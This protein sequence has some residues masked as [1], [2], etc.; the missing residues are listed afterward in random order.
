MCG[1]SWILS[2]YG[3]SKYTA[4]EGQSIIAWQFV[5]VNCCPVVQI[6]GNSLITLFDSQVQWQNTKA[7]HRIRAGQLCETAD[8]SK[9][10]P[11]VFL[12][13]L[14]F[15]QFSCSNTMRFSLSLTIFVF[16]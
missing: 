6:C 16:L 9:V 7:N 15:C 2:V 11:K 1:K 12:R 13:Y 14:F 10:S 3:C 4:T 5:Q 8:I